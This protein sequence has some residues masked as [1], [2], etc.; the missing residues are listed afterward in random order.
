MTLG[1]HIAPH[2]TD[3]SACTYNLFRNQE[4]PEIVCAVPEDCPVPAFIG[5]DQWTFDHPVRSVED[6]PPGFHETDARTAV[7]FNGFYLFYAL[8]SA[9]LMQTAWDM[10][11]RGF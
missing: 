4:F 5:P 8:A 11:Q 7:Q 3:A 6:R 1:R 10:M 2:G 9:P